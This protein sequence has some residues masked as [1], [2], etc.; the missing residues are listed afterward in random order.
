MTTYSAVIEFPRMR[1][2]IRIEGDVLSG[3]VY[4][5][6]ETPLQPPDSALAKKAVLQI[7]RYRDDPD[8]VFDLPLAVQGTAFQRD[9]WRQIC[10][11]PRGR[12]RTY[13]ELARRLGRE[14]RAV[15]QACGDNPF[16]I[17]VPCHRVVAA[18]GLG[19]FSHHLSG[20]LMEAKKWLLKHEG[21]LQMYE[22]GQLW[23]EAS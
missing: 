21:N 9:V 4:L 16:P 20:Y 8:A 5:P 18:D 1:V 22:T 19:G 23:P 15:G 2:G 12:T 11:I 6:P 10:D 17:V 13:G 3:I 14:P 7:E